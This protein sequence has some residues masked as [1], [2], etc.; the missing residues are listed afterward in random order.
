MDIIINEASG[1]SKGG[2]YFFNWESLNY[3]NSYPDD[4]ICTLTTTMEMAGYAVFQIPAG[5]N[6][7]DNTACLY[8]RLE[9]SGDIM[10]KT[11]VCNRFNTD[12]SNYMMKMFTASV[13]GTINFITDSTD[14]NV[15]KGFRMTITVS[16]DYA[17]R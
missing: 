9:F 13:T 1:Y 16:L 5:D 17:G 3:P 12:Y 15:E 2:T 7:Y 8:D 4:C 14:G 10:D 6:I 11:P